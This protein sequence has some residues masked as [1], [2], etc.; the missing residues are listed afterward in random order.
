VPENVSKQKMFVSFFLI[1]LF[2]AILYVEQFFLLNNPIVFYQDDILLIFLQLFIIIVLISASKSNFSAPKENINSINLSLFLSFFFLFFAK[3]F[4]NNE[5]I[6]NILLMITNITF[7]SIMWSLIIIYTLKI[8]KVST[9]KAILPF[10]GIIIGFGMFM[11]MTKTEVMKAVIIT[12]IDQTFSMNV[13]NF[14]FFGYN[15]ELIL[16]LINVIT[17]FTFI[18]VLTTAIFIIK[19]SKI[20]TAS[21]LILGMTGLSVIPILAIIRFLSLFKLEL[22]FTEKQS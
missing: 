19:E 10:I 4:T 7:W 1:N 12:I 8:K 15:P 21:L 6:S 18:F 3:L 14:Q 16:I 11:G 2:F 5:E 20:E 22:D 13:V 17:G 9:V